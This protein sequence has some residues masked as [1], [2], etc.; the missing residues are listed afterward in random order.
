MEEEC[1]SRIYNFIPSSIPSHLHNRPIQV[2]LFCAR[3]GGNAYKLTTIGRWP[4]TPVTTPFKQTVH[5]LEYSRSAQASPMKRHADQTIQ[6]PCPISMQ[7]GRSLEGIV[8][9]REFDQDLTSPPGTPPLVA[10]GTFDM[11]D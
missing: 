7:R 8:E 4:L 6:A 1:R 11:A 10:T 5:H 9:T 2:F 3:G